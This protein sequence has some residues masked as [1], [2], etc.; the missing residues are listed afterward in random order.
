MT[1]NMFGLDDSLTA[2][3]ERAARDA[4]HKAQNLY[5]GVLGMHSLGPR[6]GGA[7]KLMPQDANQKDDADD[8]GREDAMNLFKTVRPNI[9]QSIRAFRVADLA[10]AA[11][12]LGQHFLYAN[13]AA[14]TTKGEVLD[15]IAREFLFPK[16]FGKNFDALADC[17][18][19]MI[20]K[21]GPQPGF[22]IVLEG[23]PCAP[24]FDK[25]ARETLLDVFRDAAEF[26]A[27][28]KVQFRVFY[29][30]A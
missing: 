27:E 8:G 15:V 7:A 14:A 23:L 5:D 17:L 4:W 9:V 29:S 18:T 2:R 11:T 30:F 10:E 1:T 16:H 6:V 3:D 24:K 26:W 13:C 25:E 12:G 19:D 22:V 28:R 21:A 20:Y